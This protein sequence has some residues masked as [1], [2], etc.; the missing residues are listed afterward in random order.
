MLDHLHPNRPVAPQRWLTFFVAAAVL[1]PLVTAYQQPPQP[2]FFNQVIAC[3]LWMFVGAALPVPALRTRGA[4]KNG[5]IDSSP[6]FTH[7]LSPSFFLFGTFVLLFVGALLSVITAKSPL[8][9]LVPSIC[10]LFCATATIWLIGRQTSDTANTLA[11]AIFVAILIAAL[12]NAAIAVLQTVALTWHDDQW[13]A[14]LY[15]DRAYGNL[16]QPNLMAL[17]ALWG[18]LA[19]GWSLRAGLNR[20]GV[21]AGVLLLLLALWLTGSRT[22]WLALPV[23]FVCAFL[24]LRT[25]EIAS[26]ATAKRWRKS[27]RVFVLAALV[28]MIAAAVWFTLQ[29]IAVDRSSSIAQR[30][31]LWRDVMVL[32]GEHPFAGVGFGQLNFAWTLTPLPARSPDVF[33]HA[34]NLAL[35]LA[36]EL[37]IPLA[38]AILSFVALALSLS[39]RHSRAPWRWTAFGIVAVTLWHSLLEYPLWFAHFLMPCIAVTALLARSA[40]HE[41]PSRRHA[42][43]DAPRIWRVATTFTFVAVFAFAAWLAQGYLAVAKIYAQA[44]HFDKARA[45]ARAAQAHPV[46]G[47]FGDYAA[48]MLAGDAATLDL[49]ARPIRGVIDEKLLVAWA[50]ALERAGRV[51][52]AAHVVARAREFKA[53]ASFERLPALPPAGASAPRRVALENLR[54]RSK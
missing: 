31:A 21:S 32:I 1:F 47:Y 33:D 30:V 35:H 28:A 39:M 46:Y 7:L 3:V 6:R 43:I 40:A 19:A 4:S 38:L 26:A 17:L 50:R 48:I 5:L 23:V 11:K 51:D 12:V 41:A 36:A 14:R 22:A 13:I 18:L 27:A 49:F 16:R 9:A 8:F 25:K 52:E 42:E 54:V 44:N 34:H 20:Y 53:D 2:A 45:Q 10:V 24:Q 15:G 37:G 29:T